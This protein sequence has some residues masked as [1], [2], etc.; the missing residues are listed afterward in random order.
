MKVKTEHDGVFHIRHEDVNAY[1]QYFH[2]VVLKYDKKTDTYGLESFNFGECKGDTFDR[3][4]I[5]PNVPLK[6]LLLKGEKLSSPEKYY[7][8]VTRPRYSIAIVMDE[9]PPRKEEFEKVTLN[10]NGQAIKAFHWIP[11]EEHMES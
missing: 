5:F 2:P 3:V 7:V 11:S 4:L 1:C 9:K 8:A 10:L 6:K